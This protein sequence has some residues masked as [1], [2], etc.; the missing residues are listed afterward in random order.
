MTFRTPYITF[1]LNDLFYDYFLDVTLYPLN[2]ETNDKKEKQPSI[3]WEIRKVMSA[4][5]VLV[6]VYCAEVH[7]LQLEKF[8]SVC[9]RLSFNSTLCQLEFQLKIKVRFH[10]TTFYMHDKTR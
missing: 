7:T 1:L 10:F 9:K 2:R 8:D 5:G 4:E 6:S 3:E